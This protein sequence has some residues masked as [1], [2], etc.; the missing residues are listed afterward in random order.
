MPI[1]GAKPRKG[2]KLTKKKLADPP[3]PRNGT[4]PLQARPVRAGSLLGPS[5]HPEPRVE[6]VERPEWR[7]Q[8]RNP[9]RPGSWAIPFAYGRLYTRTDDAIF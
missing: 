1:G 4:Q 2:I 7:V 3:T 6:V 8:C 5:V 9:D